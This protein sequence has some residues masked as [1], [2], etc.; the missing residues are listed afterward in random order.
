MA[1]SRKN[2]KNIHIWEEPN[3]KVLYFF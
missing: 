2:K 3:Q 1:F